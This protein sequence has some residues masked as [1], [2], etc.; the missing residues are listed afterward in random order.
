M[1]HEYD[2]IRELDNN[3]PPWWKWGFIV[4]IIAAVC[5]C[6]IT[7]FLILVRYK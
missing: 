2:G 4:S 6:L 3:L 5:I 1:E 7:I